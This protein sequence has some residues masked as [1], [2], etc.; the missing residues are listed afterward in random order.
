MSCR[1]ERKRKRERRR[2]KG[3]EGDEKRRRARGGGGRSLKRPFLHLMSLCCG[4][5]VISSGG[6]RDE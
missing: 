1:R 6:S 4:A 3:D 2:G 5:K